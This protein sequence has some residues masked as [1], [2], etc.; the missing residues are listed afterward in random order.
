MTTEERLPRRL[1]LR[2]LLLLIFAAALSPVLVIGGIR[3]SSDIEREAR[4]R[5]EAMTLVAQEAAS[6]AEYMLDTAPALL[7]LIDSISLGDPCAEPIRG[8]IDAL[9]AFANLG[10]VDAQGTVLCSTQ[11][12]GQGSQYAS[13]PWFTTLRDTEVRL[14]N[15]MA[16]RSASTGEWTIATALRR[17]G[18]GG[19][20]DGAFLIGVPIGSLVAQ[21]TRTGLDPQADLA[22]V[23]T[24][25]Q[26]FA[27]E[28]WTQLD[29][30]TVAKLDPE[31]PVF[32][33]LNGV[34]DAVRQV[35]IVP[36]A[37]NDLYAM[38]S[39][40]KP[41]PIAVE[42][43]SAFGNFGL[44]LMAW[45]LALV[46][47]WLA[48]DRLV[49]RWLDYLR[50]IAGLYASGKLSVQ[51][52]RAKRQAPGEINVLADT[53]EEMAV[54]IRDR[55]SRMETALAARDAAMKEIHHRVKNN[56][57]IINSLLS[58]QSRKLKDRAAIAVLDDARARINALSLVHRSL[59]EHNEVRSVE[60]RSFFTEL[61][62]QLDQALGAEDQGITVAAKIDDDTIDADIAVPLALFTAEAITNSVKHAFPDDHPPLNGEVHV[63]YHINE[64]SAVLSIEDNG[65]GQENGGGGN[66][67]GSTL[68]SAFA[69]QVYGKLEEGPSSIGGRMVR[70]IIP[71]VDGVTGA[72]P[73]PTVH[74][75]SSSS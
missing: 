4:Y 15:S 67:V 72:P 14:V 50:R 29:S 66:G 8:L 68:M 19:A 17:N 53:L 75:P 62:S 24:S 54:R 47:A 58:L 20:F 5:R 71:R 12:G 34:D 28:H 38:L 16:Y 36:L 33:E 18:P 23:D 3:W 65:V 52:L 60:T 30:E 1:S 61:A 48:M 44:P 46:T 32:L 41:T 45:L 27:S 59:Y 35:A 43:V 31:K 56:L 21:L 74:E 10:V 39:A 11:D 22:L 57:Q 55:T 2:V 63:T 73:P 64:S 7:T 69:K 37:Q 51:P 26:V 13:S 70:I 40:P 25:G 49:L 6:R 9:P 42:N